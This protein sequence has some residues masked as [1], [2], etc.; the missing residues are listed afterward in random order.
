MKAKLLIFTISIS[1]GNSTVLNVPE[2]YPTIQSGIDAAINGD[3]VLVAPGT[4]IENINYNGKNLVLGSWFLVTGD[5]SYIS[6]TVIDGNQN[7][8]VVTFENGEDS[9]AVL[10]GFTIFNGMAQNGAG[11]YCENS[12]PNLNSLIIDFNHTYPNDQWGGTSGGGIFCNYCNLKLSNSIVLNNTSIYSYW[13][14]GNV[15]GGIAVTN[16]SNVVLSNVIIKNNETLFRGGGM[17]IDGSITTLTKVL[18][19]E[20][21]TS[22]AIGDIGGGGIFT[23][24]SILIL[25][26]VTMVKNH[27]ETSSFEHELGLVALFNSNLSII[28]SIFWDD[29]IQ[30]DG[31]SWDNGQIEV[32]YS[33]IEGGQESI[34]LGLNGNYELSWGLGNITED[35]LFADSINGDFTLQ[36]GSPCIDAGTDFFVWEGDTLVDMSPDEY[37]GSSPDMGA[38]EFDGNMGLTGDINQDGEVNILDV[39]LT[40]NIILSGEYNAPADLNGDGNVDVLDVVL[41]VNLI[42]EG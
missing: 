22:D 11:I 14:D 10:Y 15:G 37:Y 30:L 17:F 8:S 2:D 19:T 32:E 29:T 12:D 16:N 41:L 20:N 21:Y 26:Q 18:L 36:E 42:L 27:T 31:N 4:Y 33:L 5:T 24:N 38:F 34:Y 40:I 39:V 7:G 1:L 25:N 9:T 28:N 13:F 23:S 35:P 3:T 6:Q